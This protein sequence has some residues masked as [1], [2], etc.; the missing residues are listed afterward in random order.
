MDDQGA[1]YN[2]FIMNF[3]EGFQ[4][5]R[6]EMPR[7]LLWPIL[8]S[9]T[10]ELKK[11]F[12]YADIKRSLQAIHPEGESLNPGNITQALRSAASLQVSKDIMPIVLDY[13]ATT[14]RFNIVDRGFLIWLEN[15][16]RRGL[17]ELAGLPTDRG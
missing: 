1:R 3:S 12:S 6:L 8:T 2:A 16:D 14:R 7:W 11:G 5:T 9:S 13:D 4:E 15:Q 17:L 10:D